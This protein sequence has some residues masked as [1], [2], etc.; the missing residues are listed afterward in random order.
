[1]TFQIA[2]PEKITFIHIPK[3]SGTSISKWFDV[4][5]SSNPTVYEKHE[6]YT[7][8][9]NEH[10]GIREVN[11]LTSDTGF[12]FSVVRNPWDYVVSTY[13]FLTS[14]YKNWWENR[15]INN[16]V[17][18]YTLK[19]TS[20]ILDEHL[21]LKDISPIDH[22][23]WGFD[24]SWL[25]N[26]KLSFRMF[27]E[28]LPIWS[29]PFI[30]GYNFSTPLC[31][32]INDRVHVMRFENLIQDFKLIQEMIDFKVSLPRENSS[33]RNKYQDYYDENTKNLISSYFEEDID[34][35]KYTY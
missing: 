27:V 9:I 31:N 1:M 12:V 7:K 5:C 26:P 24:N 19:T 28:Q 17:S 29:C 33:A 18:L 10:W 21:P 32:W 8:N 34:K 2:G 4:V 3:T 23:S 30:T 14:T 25:G 35:F 13:T 22:T 6:F 11:Q 16:T 20:S 15:L